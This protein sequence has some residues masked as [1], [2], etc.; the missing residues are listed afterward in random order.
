MV[1]TDG[2]SLR[3][4][5]ANVDP[6]RE[7]FAATTIP[8]SIVNQDN[9]LTAVPQVMGLQTEFVEAVNEVGKMTAVRE[10][11]EPVDPIAEGRTNS[12]RRTA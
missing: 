10:T 5:S 9:G 12:R 1:E 3:I 11:C 8:N 4:G 7:H 2:L 6:R